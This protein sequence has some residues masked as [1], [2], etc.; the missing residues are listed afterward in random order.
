M[1]KKVCIGNVTIPVPTYE[2]INVA[3]TFKTFVAWS[4]HLLK[5]ILDRWIRKYFVIINFYLCMNAFVD[6]S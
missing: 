6:L 4:K 5:P 2:V 3:H 1:I